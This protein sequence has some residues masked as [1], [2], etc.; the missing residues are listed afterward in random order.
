MLTVK[1]TLS[2]VFIL[3]YV[4]VSRQPESVTHLDC[5]KP[6]HIQDKYVI[7]VLILRL[8][9]PSGKQTTNQSSISNTLLISLHR[10]TRDT[11]CYQTKHCTKAKGGLQRL[12]YKCGYDQ[13]EWVEGCVQ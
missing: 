10:A 3:L 2:G 13:D 5:F 1:T 8:F 7:Y 12:L 4:N 11:V 9:G 6:F